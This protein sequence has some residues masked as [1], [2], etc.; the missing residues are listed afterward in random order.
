MQD[1]LRYERCVF[2]AARGAS[3]RN[4]AAPDENMKLAKSCV[5][6]GVSKP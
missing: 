5:L 6:G 3:S 1:Q 4:F 2:G